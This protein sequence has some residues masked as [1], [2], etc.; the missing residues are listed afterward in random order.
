LRNFRSRRSKS[1]QKQRNPSLDE[2]TTRNTEVANYSLFADYLG[3]PVVG[4]KR[5]PT[6][7]GA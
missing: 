5:W 7:M 6:Q 4:E 3:K 2:L 1:S